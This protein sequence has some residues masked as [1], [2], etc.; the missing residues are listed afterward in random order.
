MLR[1]LKPAIIDAASDSKA[2]GVPKLEMEFAV[3][4]AQTAE[5]TAP[6]PF[7]PLKLGGSRNETTRVKI[8]I[9][10]LKKWSPTSADGGI[11]DGVYRLDR[12]SKTALPI[13]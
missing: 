5:I 2:A 4:Y 12:V 10:D 8:T 3:V 1:P 13:E 11:P 7:V 6:T 9:D